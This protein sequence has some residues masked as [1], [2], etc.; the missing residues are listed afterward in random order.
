LSEDY[1]GTVELTEIMDSL[2]EKIHLDEVP[3]FTTIQKVLSTYPI[4]HVQPI[5]QPVHENVLRLGRE[6]T[7]YAR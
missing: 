2:R 7:G 5:T 1:R 3:H 6:E 4:I